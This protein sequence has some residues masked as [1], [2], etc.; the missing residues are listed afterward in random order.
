MKIEAPPGIFDILPKDPREQWRSSYLWSYVEAAIR[1]IAEEYGYQEIRTPIMERT[2]L[3]QRGVGETSEI[4]T[5]EMYTF[6]D[7]G[8]RSLSLRPEGTA[9]VIRAFIEHRLS[10][11]LP[12]HKFYYIGPMFRY[13]RAQAGRYRQHHQFGAEAIGNS[14]PEQDA[15]L[16]DLLYT[17]YTRLG[18][19][20]LRVVIN[21][22][23]DT[24][25]RE[26]Y[27]EALL[28]YLK[29]YFDQL[30]LDSKNRFSINPLRILDSKDPKDREIIAG[31]PSILDFLNKECSDHFQQVQK[32]L[33]RL[34]IPY[35]VDSKIVRGLDYYNK[36]VFEIIAE[37]LGA[38]NSIGGGG[39]YDGLIQELG[40]PNLPALGFGTGI[41]RIIQTMLKQNVPLP[42]PYCPT[43]YLIPLGEKAK[44]TCFQIVHDLRAAGIRAQMDFSGRKIG[45]VMN[46]ANQIRSMYVA[47]VGNDELD[48][49]Q[50]NLKEMATGEILQAPLYH[51]TR[52][53]KTF[54]AGDDFI[55]VWEEMHTPFDEPLE[56]R[57]FLNKLQQ[58]INNTK[59]ITEDLQ[60]AM[61]KIK[62]II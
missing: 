31:A 35:E 25:C 45:K 36:T 46:Y 49:K 16:I 24:E 52:I 58:S 42:Q 26:A 40:G 39:R 21:S 27:R 48:T 11:E 4:V 55:R 41:E 53:L 5:K 38:Q 7:K 43:I 10:H 28:K 29:V 32:L 61:E 54:E 34:N 33:E 37:E 8:K 12:I 1:M 20:N 59:K 51:L 15:E 22:I 57:F 47:V 23:G 13:E 50:V 30:S 60:T 18:L 9:P 14:A 6:E 62:E 19:K 3:F 2:E 56:A 44:D 17:L